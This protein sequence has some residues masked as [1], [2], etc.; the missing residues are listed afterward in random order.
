MLRVTDRAVQKV[1]ELM[2]KE[3]KDGYGLRVMQ[4]RLAE[5]LG[6]RPRGG[7]KSG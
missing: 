4:G 1:R 6:E 3:G 2:V 5:I 7:R